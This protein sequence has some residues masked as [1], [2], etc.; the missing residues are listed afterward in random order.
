MGW[1]SLFIVNRLLPVTLLCIANLIGVTIQ[2]TVKEERVRWEPF[3]RVKYNEIRLVVPLLL[4]RHSFGNGSLI[5]LKGAAE[6]SSCEVL[7]RNVVP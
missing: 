7:S 2:K 6:C 5:L 4:Y 3:F 1:E